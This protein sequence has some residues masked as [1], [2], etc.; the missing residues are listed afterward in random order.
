MDLC[1]EFVHNNHLENNVIFY[2]ST[3]NVIKLINESKFFILGSLYEG[4]PISILEAMSAG[5]PIIAPNVGGIPDVVS[6]GRNGFLYSVNNSKELCGCIEKIFSRND[7]SDEI[8]R[9]NRN[10]SK[11]YK[12]EICAK[13][14][15]DL[16]QKNKTPLKNK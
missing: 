15:L 8:S 1:K 2:G 11:K 9:N 7:L 6:D 3:T 16:F 10:D 5:L 4:N 13:E 14:Y 12:I